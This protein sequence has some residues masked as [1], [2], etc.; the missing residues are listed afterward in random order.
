M[1]PA[2]ISMAPAGTG[3]RGV[4]L[5]ETLVASALFAFVIAGVYL[6]HTT[7]QSTW[8]RGEMKADLQQNARVG[9]DRL[10]QEL[11]M[12]GYDPE[13]ALATVN[14]LP[15]GSLRAASATCL[16]FATYNLDR[17]AAPPTPYS[18]QVSYYRDGSM[19]RRREDRWNQTA[20]FTD[21]SSAQSPPNAEQQ[22]TGV[23]LLSYSFF[24]AYN[25]PIVPAQI[26]S[27]QRCPPVTGAPAQAVTLLGYDQLAQVRR[28]TVKLRTSDARPRIAAEFYTL[29]TD[30]RLRNR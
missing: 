5:V 25:A 13:G 6:L 4:T 30:V 27:A 29:T 14:T 21:G 7:M 11:R 16:A 15:R 12:A 19:L 24:D 2:K 23:H 28:V 26:I 22:A 9:L 1:W 3:R 8:S 17:T 20:A 18:T 10:A